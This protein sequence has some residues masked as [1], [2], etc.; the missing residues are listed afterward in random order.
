[1]KVLEEEQKQKT[2]MEL[3]EQY[4]QFKLEA[5][6]QTKKKKKKT[7]K[8]K[9][10]LKPKR[11]ISAFFLFPKDLRETLSAENKNMLEVKDPI[12]GKAL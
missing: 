8:Q 12:G 9:D 7:K 4:L 3:L 11:P 2:A 10:P 1:M 5:D 6:Q